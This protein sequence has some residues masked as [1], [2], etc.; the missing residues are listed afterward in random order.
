MVNLDLPPVYTGTD[1]TQV[2]RLQTLS[3]GT[4]VPWQNLT[5]YTVAAQIR[6]EDGGDLVADF[7]PT[8]TD[9]PNAEITFSI[10]KLVTAAIVPGRYRYDCLLQ[11][12]GGDVLDPVFGGAVTV[13]PTIS[14]FA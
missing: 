4:L 9:G 7:N 10:D 5:G 14:Q 6:N 1:Y 11:T 3:N 12:A 2:I 13:F 8:V